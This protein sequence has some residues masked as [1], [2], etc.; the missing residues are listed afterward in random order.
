MVGLEAVLQ[1]SFSA[2]AIHSIEGSGDLTVHGEFLTNANT[3]TNFTSQ[4]S[5]GF[6]TIRANHGRTALNV[7]RCD[8]LSAVNTHMEISG[9]TGVVRT[10]K[11]GV[12]F[13]INI[14]SSESRCSH[15][16]DSGED[17]KSFHLN[18]LR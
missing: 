12:R 13:H 3:T 5:F 4:D 11:T 14:G 2:V 6:A 17:S 9:G 7:P 8:A 16:S 15:Q 10:S 1:T 18:R